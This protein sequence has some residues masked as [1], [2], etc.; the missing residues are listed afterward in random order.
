MEPRDFA[1]WAN[2]L[3]LKLTEATLRYDGIPVKYMGDQYLC[4]FSGA[5]HRERAIG[6]AV[7]SRGLVAED[8]R[9]GLSA[10]D[11]YLG[12]IGHPDYARPDIMG[13]VVNVAF[14]TMEW[15]E[16][17]SASGI[18]ATKCVI[19][20]FGGSVQVGKTETVEFRGVASP[21]TVCEIVSTST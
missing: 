7:C 21:V 13:E 12:S 11:V 4:F 20:A 5:R 10:G 17:N 2:G 8:L 16:T 6:A 15:A 9:A 3:F 14:L 18:A 19:D 1:T